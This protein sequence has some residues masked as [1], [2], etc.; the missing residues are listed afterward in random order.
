[1]TTLVLLPGMDGTGVLFRDFVAALPL[2]F[3]PLVIPYPND[4]KFGYPELEHLVR[5]ALPHGER[6]IL[7]G[8]SFSGPLA[9]SIAA[10]SPPRLLGVVL[11]C[12]FARCPHPLL[13]LATAVMKPLPALRV[14]SFIQ[15]RNL[16]GRFS[17]P[18][19]RA[20][21]AE[22]QKLVAANTLKSRLEAV[23]HVDV[24]EELRR[25]TVPILDLRARRDRVVSHASGDYI[26]HI[27]TDA[28]VADLEAPHL[29]LQTVPQEAVS[30]IGNFAGT[31]TNTRGESTGGLV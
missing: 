14:P 19:L 23:A 3:R 4:P 18:R 1:M 16:F 27:R 21:L 30:V 22:I 17:S 5:G 20:Q 24:S 29:L 11:C 28:K 31:C 25:I 9:I 10:S 13:P 8:E 12:T 26:R 15:H 6:F 2:E 7:L